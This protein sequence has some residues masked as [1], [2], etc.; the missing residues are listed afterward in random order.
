[1]VSNDEPNPTALWASQQDNHNRIIL[2]DRI[3]Y[4]L[5]LIFSS[6]FTFLLVFII[7]TIY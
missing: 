1:M 2:I 7:Y 6:K 5:I 3:L 4:C